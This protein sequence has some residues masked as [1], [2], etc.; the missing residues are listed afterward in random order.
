M[1]ARRLY[2]TSATRLRSAHHR[3]RTRKHTLRT[4][5]LRVWAEFSVGRCSPDTRTSI[6]V[7]APWH[8]MS[9]AHANTARVYSGRQLDGALNKPIAT[10]TS[11]RNPQTAGRCNVVWSAHYTSTVIIMNAARAA[12]TDTTHTHQ[13]A[14]HPQYAVHRHLAA[15]APRRRAPKVR[16]ILRGNGCTAALPHTLICLAP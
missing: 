14:G 8:H 15:G 11:M 1:L 5:V 9:A 16:P 10:P 4:V 3:R 6:R 2:W 13:H 12:N 7:T